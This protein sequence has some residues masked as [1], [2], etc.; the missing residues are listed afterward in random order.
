[1]KVWFYNHFIVA[2]ITWPSMIYDLPISFGEELKA[3]ATK[4]LKR[5]L[6]ITKSI[7]ESA[8]YRSKDHF[9]LGFI[10]LVTHL[11]KMQ[12]CRMHMLKY[13]QDGSGNNLYEYMR[14]RD[15][16]PVNGIVIPIKSKL[17]KPTIALKT[18][19]CNFYL[20]DIAFNHYRQVLGKSKVK[21]DR[22]NTLKRVDKDDEE[23]CLTHSYG[24]A[25]QRGL[26]EL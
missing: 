23:T 6:G 4:Y 9:G 22:H 19:E 10:D 2:F 14:E 24:Y 18:A 1:M 3:V 7:T 17:W 21:M 5:W 20:D 25:I 16:P 8:L 13:S 11:K 12:V 26:A 15:K